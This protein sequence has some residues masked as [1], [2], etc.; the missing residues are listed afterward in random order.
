M[1]SNA[2][3]NKIIECV[4]SICMETLKIKYS[5]SFIFMLSGTNFGGCRWPKG[6][7]KSISLEVNV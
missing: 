4:M 3:P 1:L 6:F 5:Y 7:K 2:P